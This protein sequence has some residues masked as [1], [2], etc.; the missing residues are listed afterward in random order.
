MASEAEREGFSHLKFLHRLIAEQATQRRERSIAY[1]IRE[2]RFR[3][4]KT[5]A[6]FD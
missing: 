2:A 1:P 5:L 4:P 3:E 6:T